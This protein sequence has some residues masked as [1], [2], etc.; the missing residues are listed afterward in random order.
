MAL[1]HYIRGKPP[2]D[3]DNANRDDWHRLVP[4]DNTI[5]FAWNI[6]RQITSGI[7]FIHSFNLV[8]RSLH[9]AN[10]VSAT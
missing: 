4:G 8:Y 3:K 1:D 6:M 9:L 7:E 2:W 5:K 10:T